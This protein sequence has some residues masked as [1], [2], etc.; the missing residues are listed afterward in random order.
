MPVDDFPM[1]LHVKGVKEGKCNGPGQGSRYD[2]ISSAK[3]QQRP[4]LCHV[5][6][7]MGRAWDTELARHLAKAAVL[8][9]YSV[10]YCEDW[11][12]L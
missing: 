3:W 5:N 9:D 1:I 7:C 8:F 6:R 10:I 11:T 4:P 12:C 2:C